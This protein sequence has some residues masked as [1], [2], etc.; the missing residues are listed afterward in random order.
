MTTRVPLLIIAVEPDASQ[1]KQLGSMAKRFLNAEFVVAATAAA[2][3]K[4]LGD[5]VP[6]LILTPVLLPSRDEALLTEHLR[7][8]GGA[9]AHVQTLAIPILSSAQPPTVREPASRLTRR[10]Q[11]A[12]AADSGC[13]LSLFADQVK[14][15][16]ERAATHQ[17]ARADVQTAD[18][19]IVTEADGEQRPTSGHARGHSRSARA[20]PGSGVAHDGARA[21]VAGPASGYRAGR[22][23]GVRG[24]AAHG[25]GR[26]IAAGSAV[27]APVTPPAP[28][29][30]PADPSHARALED[31]LGLIARPGHAQHLWRVTVGLTD[32]T[33]LGDEPA[34]AVPAPVSVAAT[35]VRRRPRAHKPSPPLDDWAYFDP[36]QTGFKALI[37]RLDEIAAQ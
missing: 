2:A 15:Y 24:V 35:P 11:R 7:Q 29:T 4:A 12:A 6:D 27:P 19:P 13:D 5:R 22:R 31:E 23:G 16:L 33:A 25:V 18:A 20:C 26:R 9:A 37:R 21:G 34:K 17:L 30:Q 8:L 36:T 3:L 10:R 1:A 28:E 14:I 32:E